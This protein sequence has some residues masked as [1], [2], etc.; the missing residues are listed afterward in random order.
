MEPY[1]LKASPGTD[2]WRK[3]PAT[4]V[5]NAPTQVLEKLDSQSFYRARVTV[6]APWTR[7]YDQGGLLIVLPGSSGSKRPWIKAGIEYVG[8][9]ANLSVV[10]AKEWADWS[11]SALEDNTD[12]ITI[13]FEREIVDAK[14]GKGS[15]LSV[16]LVQDGNRA[17]IPARKVT[18]AFEHEG[19]VDVGI[20]A[21]R[22]T[23]NG[24]SDEDV[25]SVDL[26][27]YQSVQRLKI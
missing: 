11:L 13:E 25:L 8:G 12:T 2:L 6:S 27:D 10:A 16:Y 26:K 24:E 3:P 18:W 23:K 21:A 9:R 19:D 20:Y 15:S 14:K 22:P 7:L 5:S 4:D 17:E 1:K